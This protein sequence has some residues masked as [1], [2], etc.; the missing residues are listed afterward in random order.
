MKKRLHLNIFLMLTIFFIYLNFGFTQIRDFRTS[1]LSIDNGLSQNQVLCIYEDSKGLLWIGTQDGLNLY[2]GYTFKIFRHEPGNENSLLDYAVNAVCETEP[3]I[4]WIGTRS[5]LSRFDLSAGRFMHY[6]HNPDSANSLVD[7]YVWAILKDNE[8]SLWIGT[9]IG[10]SVFNPVTETF[11][12]FT[13]NPSE[14][15][16]ISHNFILSLVEDN[17]KNIWIGGRGGLDRYD[18]KQKKFFNYKLF[19]QKPK[20]ISLNGIMSL[21]LEK[22]ILWIG[23]YSGMYSVNLNNLK[24]EKI[25]IKKHS[26]IENGKQNDQSKLNEH[27]QIS[28]RWIT[29]GSD[30][31][32]WAGTY[33]TGL[34]RY[35]TDTGKINL[36]TRSD[37][38]E[39]ISEDYISSL[40]EDKHGVLWIGTSASGLNKFNRSSEKFQTLIIPDMSRNEKSGISSILEDR[41]GN[42]W[43]GT[44][45]G[46]IVKVTNQYSDNAVLRYY[47]TDKYLKTYFSPIEIRTFY[48]DKNGNIW[49]GSF[50]KGIYVIDPVTDKIKRI[51]N[52]RNDIKTIAS[53]F[54]HCIFESAD[55]TIWIGTGAGGLNK[56]NP[57]DNSFTH[58]RHDPNS[59]KSISSD[60][61]TAI[62]EDKNGILWVG[63]SV[64]GLNRFDRRTGVF[65]HFIHDVTDKKSIS[66][67]RIL[68]L[69]VDKKSNLWIGTFGG[70]LNRWIPGNNSFEYYSIR[71]GLP[72][73]I[74]N[75]ITEDAAGNLWI[76]TDKGLSVFNVE[77]KSFKN[78]D[79]NDGLQGNEFLHNAG[80]ASKLNHN[81]Y[82]GGVSGLNI[83]NPEDL[84]TNTRE[85]NVIF[86]DFK[87]YNKSVQPGEESALKKN[88]I[89]ADVINLS[90]DENFITFEFA[91]L[92]F[93]N[94]EKNQYAFKMEGFNQDWIYSGNQR[95]ATFTNLDPG[96]YI[97]HV[98]AANSD[99]RWN[100]A[101]VSITV[102]LHP[103]W[104]QTWWAY[105]LYTVFIVSILYS[106]RQYEMKRVQ[107]RNELQRKDFEAKKLQEVDQLKSHFFANISHEFRTPLTLILG[108]L[109]KFES[110]TVDKIEIE[111]YGI[112]KRNA[113]RL[114]QLINQ[115]L[116]LSKIE[117]GKSRLNVSENDIVEFVNRIF[118]SF[119][120]YADQKNIKLLFN[121]K[122]I[123]E[124]T[125]VHINLF[126]D[127][128]KMEK[129]ISNL[130]SNAVKYTPT[131]NEIEVKVSSQNDIVEIKVINTGVT[132]SQADLVH[133]FDRYY[134]VH[135]AESGMFEG[136][137]I[138][139]ALVKEL[140]EMHKGTI[141]VS[142]EYDVTEFNVKVPS[143]KDHFK[144]DEINS[145][146]EY[147]EL[148]EENNLFYLNEESTEN[149]NPQLLTPETEKDI[150]LVVEDHSDLRKYIK[151]TLSTEYQ[152]FES[153][154][155]KNGFDQAA[156][157]IPDLIISDV[158]MPEIDGYT[159]CKKIKTNVKTN[160]I[161][162]IL[163]TA[164]ASTEDKLEG[165]ELGA[166]DYLIK[167]FNPDEL[168]LRVRNL[169]K[170]REEL[171]KKF[172]SEMV[173]KPTD[174]VVPSSQVQFMEKLKDIIESNLEDES[175]GVDKLSDEMGMSRSQLHR[176]LKAITNQ[177][178]TEF[179][180]NF[181]LQR[182]AQLILQDAGSMS[183]IAYKVGFNSQAYFNKSFQE[184]FGCSPSQYKKDGK[185]KL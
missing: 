23:S 19:P 185:E 125:D 172:T 32:I 97:F 167:P 132:I 57:V 53:D 99:G 11:I 100:E 12:N 87:I 34:I 83:F 94:P 65:E 86:T 143:G 39:S 95:F 50:G 160:H 164:K 137:G 158:M 150:I 136:T 81:I 142:S 154:N 78:Y 22:N 149:I 166:D 29:A 56:F 6:K 181:R 102:I 4:F 184:L 106:F 141:A 115:L 20:D 175:F 31:T 60:E 144:E 35:R 135:K 42:M 129:I 161:P 152:I 40:L 76:T 169:I 168:K 92:D 103:P 3:G 79:K 159:L 72:S 54:I 74:I 163:L 25:S 131:G 30:N 117:A 119:A 147:D 52:E 182:A 67:N 64:G 27:L 7:N 179:I 49:I 62:C 113:R 177:S 116:E 44:L 5:G 9:R 148:Q 145:I 21:C 174:V 13:Y 162:V 128:D 37:K 93:N 47:N 88:I 153:A 112:M 124:K 2:D 130:I 10:L 121:E 8:G 28:V 104:W 51:T 73:N 14:N 68:C 157:I 96:E 16:S 46:D 48:E 165:L 183:E 146:P 55:G 33:G 26:L 173:F 105:I 61:A 36:Y 75:Y 69:F 122:N 91:S 85:P 126:F 77:S 127:N 18:L 176:K 108:L 114:L 45:T 156:E 70:G 123:T 71:D 133:L 82:I 107:L 66:S 41:S 63:T 140:V 17:N 138:G 109:Q 80:Y 118:V 98:K 111:D 139:L 134:K 151:N 180:R 15:N 170:T 59:S 120:S 43:V 89:Y 110:K 84:I 178:T 155:G 1:S 38:A 171:R 58:Y 24:E 101:G 90:Y